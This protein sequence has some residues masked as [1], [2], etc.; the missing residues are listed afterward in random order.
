M[1]KSPIDL[2]SAIFFFT[3][4]EAELKAKIPYFWV[5]DD[6][7]DAELVMKKKYDALKLQLKE[8]IDAG[9]VGWRNKTCRSELELVQ[10]QQPF[11]SHAKFEISLW[12]TFGA[13]H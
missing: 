8:K 13:L 2:D 7:G 5:V 3:N 6:R 12:S 11:H 1:F 10:E 4:I 9:E